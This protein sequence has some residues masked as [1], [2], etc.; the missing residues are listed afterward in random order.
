MNRDIERL[1]LNT[2][3][4]RMDTTPTHQYIDAQSPHCITLLPTLLTF[5]IVTLTI[6][7]HAI[8]K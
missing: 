7:I 2:V 5:T 3:V 6:K 1:G 4:P 8:Y